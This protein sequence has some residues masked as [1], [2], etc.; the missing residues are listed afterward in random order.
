MSV[1]FSVPSSFWSL[2]SQDDRSE[3]IR[4]RNNFHASEK[5]SSKDRRSVTFRRELT[6]VIEFLE[7]ST[8]NL[9]ARCIVAGICF[10][11]GIIC[12]NTRQLKVLLRRCKSAIN[13]AFQQLGYAAVRTRLKAR[14][15]VV[16]ILHSLEEDQTIRKQWTIRVVTPH[17]RFCFVSSFSAKGLPEITEDDLVEEKGIATV[18]QRKVTFVPIEVKIG[19]RN[20][21]RTFSLD[22]F[23]K[24]SEKSGRKVDAEEGSVEEELVMEKS[25]S[26]GLEMPEDWD[27]YG[28]FL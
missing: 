11:D 10:A 24:R 25:N 14:K 16:G 18:Y 17:A 20:E 7:R 2:L 22:W 19:E 26:L 6:I 12:V 9:E 4:I 23:E 1:D 27:I 28:E 15:C 21:G 13:G 8:E 3:Y 5:I